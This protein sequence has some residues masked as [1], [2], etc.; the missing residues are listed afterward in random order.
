[1]SGTRLAAMPSAPPPR[2][3]LFDSGVGGLSLLHTLR[4]RVPAARIDYLADSVHAPYG[5]RDDTFILER[6]L[7]IADSLFAAGAQALVVA[8]NTA[9]AVAIDELRR[10]HPQ[11][12]IVGIEPGLKPAIAQTC[13][14]RVGIMATTATLRSARWR[15]LLEREGGGRHVHE[16][17]CPGLAAAIERGDPGDPALAAE[18]ESNCR[19]LRAAGVDVVVLGCTHYPFVRAQIERAL[20]MGVAV[21]DTAD[22][23]AA[24]V[25]RVVAPADVR[26]PAAPPAPLPL[27]QTTGDVQRLRRFASHWLPFEVDVRPAPAEL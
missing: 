15:T 14:G 16:Q 2:I 4:A 8:C 12:A 21:I 22:A 17:P 27:L 6:S 11:R 13:S 24:Q 23:V 25:A 5:E 26:W 9:T 18:V 20:G 10:R 3:G 1:M 7:R 19:A